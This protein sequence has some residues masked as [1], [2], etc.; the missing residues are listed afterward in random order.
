MIWKGVHAQHKI[1]IKL[2]EH[3]DNVTHQNVISL[4]TDK[5]AVSTQDQYKDT[6]DVMTECVAHC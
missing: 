1:T 2:K 4:Y 5:H 3:D 6:A